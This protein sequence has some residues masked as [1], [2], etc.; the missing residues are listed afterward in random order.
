MKRQCWYQSLDLENSSSSPI[1]ASRMTINVTFSQIRSQAQVL[2][3][4]LSPGIRPAQRERHAPLYGHAS[5]K[6]VG[7]E[8]VS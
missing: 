6:K 7:R 4:D 1:T 8:R 3:P 2:H 5:V